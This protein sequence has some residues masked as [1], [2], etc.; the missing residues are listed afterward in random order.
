MRI[1]DWSSDVCSSDLDQRQRQIAYAAQQGKEHQRAQPV[2]PSRRNGL[3]RLG[4]GQHQERPLRQ[5]GK[6]GDRQR[7]DDDNPYRNC[8]IHSLELQRAFNAANAKRHEDAGQNRS[9]E[10]WVAKGWAR[11]WRSWWE[12]DNKK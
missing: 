4:P 9:E 10:R 7:Q 6:V 12:P 1:S 8:L 11:S 2:K 5:E 3:A